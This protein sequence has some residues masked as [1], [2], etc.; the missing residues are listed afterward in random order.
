MS[1]PIIRN[2]IRRTPLQ[3]VLIV[4]FV[5]QIFVA[6]GLTG[7]LALRNGQKAVDELAQQ[8]QCEVADRVDQHLDTYLA[9][10]HQIN[11]LNLDAIERGMLNLTDLKSAG[12]YFWKQSQT[13]PQISFVGY[14]LQDNAGVGAGRWLKGHD[15]VISVHRG[16]QL[17]DLSY[18]TDNQGNQTKLVYETDYEAIADP[19]YVDTVKAGKPIWSRIYAAEGF[20]NYVAASAN[21]PIYDQNHKLL[22]VLSIDLLLSHISEFLQ[23]IRVSASGQVFIL[24]R[25]GR[26]IASSS[27]QAIVFKKN[28]QLERYSIYDHP[29]PLMRGIALQLQQKFQA[30]GKIQSTQHFDFLMNGQRRYVQVSPWRD[31]FGLD[32]LIVVTMPESDFMAQINANT[33]ITVLLCLSALAIATLLGILTSGWITQPILALNQASKAIADGNLNQQVITSRIQE[34]E[35]LGKSFNQMAAQLQISFTA[36]EGI[37]AELEDRVAQRTQELSYKNTQLNQTLAELNRTQ[38]QMIQAEKMSALGQMV[39]G[40]AHEINNPVNFIYGNLF[41]IN[42][43]IKDLMSLVEAYQ[44]YVLNPP[45][46]IQNKIKQID[47]EFLTQDLSNLLQSMQVGAERIREIVL[48]LRNFSRLDEAELKAVDLH[49]GL[50][51]TLLILHHRLEATANRPAIEVIKDYSELPLVECYAGQMN[52]V[53]MNLLTNAIDALEESHSGKTWQA[54][55]SNPQI[56]RISTALKDSNYVQIT[57]A[58]NG[59]GIPEDVRSLIFN[60]FFTT[61]PIGKG[62]GLGLSISYQIITEKHHGKLECDSTLQQGT[63]FYIEIPVISVYPHL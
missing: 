1:F 29:D 37:N 36:L 25:S 45:L 7:Y 54:I 21:T 51:N 60:P 33:Q 30:P 15:I 31:Q 11:Q 10:P 19:W 6:V 14:Y 50:N 46:A 58:D 34:L 53:F 5:L 42:T 16:G 39:A 22:G 35:A 48:S 9:L 23:Q 52:Q 55:E 20:D 59:I 40:V 27:N 17:K 4:P 3:A 44:Q 32:W 62:T 28:D 43:Y 13:F 8:L 38:T 47:L 57:I 41:H 18:A 63:K 61:K 56:I 12:R 24:E 49:E 2:F 26:L